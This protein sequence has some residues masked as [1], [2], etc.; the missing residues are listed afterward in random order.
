MQPSF[1]SRRTLL[2]AGAVVSFGALAGCSTSKLL[3]P[4]SGTGSDQTGATLGY[5]NALRAKNGLEPLSR[6]PVA[7]AAAMDQAGRMARAGKMEHNIGL[8]ANFYDRMKGQ[9]VVLPAAEN[10]AAGQDDAA[11][12]Y[13][14]WFR[15]PKHLQNMLGAGYRGLGVAVVQNP[16]TGN[17]PYWAMVLSR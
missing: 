16:A 1:L 11:R 7:A 3:T 13:D 12:S 15:S 10:I 5:V 6:D 9:G 8:G 17:R 2:K 4:D 14:A